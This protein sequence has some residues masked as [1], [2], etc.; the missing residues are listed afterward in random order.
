M[1]WNAVRFLA[2]G[3]DAD[4]YASD[5]FYKLEY[6]H[7][8]IA[9]VSQLPPDLPNALSRIKTPSQLRLHTLL[10][11]YLFGQGEDMCRLFDQD[12]GAD[13]VAIAAIQRGE[14]VRHKSTFHLTKEE[15][16]WL[17]IDRI[18]RPELYVRKMPPEHV[19][20]RV[21]NEGYDR[22]R[23]NLILQRSAAEL[24]PVDR[25]CQLLLRAYGSDDGVAY[26]KITSS[27]VSPVVTSIQELS[28]ALN[29]ASNDMHDRG[30]VS[31]WPEIMDTLQSDGCVHDHSPSIVAT[32]VNSMVL[33]RLEDP[34]ELLAVANHPMH[35]A[36]VTEHPFIVPGHFAASVMHHDSPHLNLGEYTPFAVDLCVTITWTGRFTANGYVPGR[37]TARMFREPLCSDE[38]NGHPHPRSDARVASDTD[39]A[40]VRVP[41]GYVEINS[42]QLCTLTSMGRM[43]IRWGMCVSI[44]MKG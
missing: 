7:S 11:K 19:S 32:T 44:M 35:I 36:T 25:Y 40:L 42:L 10:C 1:G 20:Q 41:V 8:D 31:Y 39:S 16:D 29:V 33:F 6:S 15:S 12:S 18:L 34:M 22:D 5:P 24:S 3:E 37:L 21:V 30:D 26:R 14:L 23:L 38:I 27:V 43:V 4:V 13:A 28:E 9:M 2:A 17:H